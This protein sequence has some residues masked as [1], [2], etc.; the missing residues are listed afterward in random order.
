MPDMPHPCLITDLAS[1]QDWLSFKDKVCHES[2]ISARQTHMINCQTC[3]TQSHL[4]GASKNTQ[5]VHQAMP[6]PT[7][8]EGFIGSTTTP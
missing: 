4:L 2:H 8:K 5:R 1:L 6:C 7:Q 3:D